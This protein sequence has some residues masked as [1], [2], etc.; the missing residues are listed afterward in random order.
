MA[1]LSTANLERLR[2]IH[3]DHIESSR[4]AAQ[5]TPEWGAHSVGFSGNCPVEKCEIISDGLLAIC[6]V[7]PSVMMTEVLRSSSL[8]DSQSMKFAAVANELRFEA[9]LSKDLD[10]DAGDMCVFALANLLKIVNDSSAIPRFYCSCKTMNAINFAPDSSLTYRHFFLDAVSFREK[11]A[12]ILNSK[13][14]NWISG[15]LGTF[16]RLLNDG[17]K[18]RLRVC[19][20]LFATWDVSHDPRKGLFSIWACVDSLFGKNERSSTK[21]MIAR[22]AEFT[23]QDSEEIKEMYDVRCDIIHGRYSDFDL[24]IKST[25]IALEVTRCSLRKIIDTGVLP[26]AAST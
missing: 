20:D 18:G 23:C 12:H 2:K 21:K 11:P 9:I 3:N 24:V 1:R 6:P 10:S 19:A 5:N 4:A 26:I 13:E 22:A 14:V 8:N 15:G 7:N 16:L 25:E 17:S